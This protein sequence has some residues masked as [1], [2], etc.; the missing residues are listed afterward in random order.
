MSKQEL[1]DFLIEEGWLKNKLGA[2]WAYLQNYGEYIWD[3][4][5]I[6]DDEEYK[7]KYIFNDTEEEEEKFKTYKDFINYYKNIW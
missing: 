5:Y 4:I 2:D 3:Y 7:V 1:E 6:D